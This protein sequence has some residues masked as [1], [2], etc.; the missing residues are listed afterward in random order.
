MQSKI[1]SLEDMVRMSSE[2]LCLEQSKLVE[3]QKARL[4]AEKHAE[5]ITAEKNIA[6]EC[7][8]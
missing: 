6:E 7:F 1:A 3:E 2:Q 5:T 4:M 8:K